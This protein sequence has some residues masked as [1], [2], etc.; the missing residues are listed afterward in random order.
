MAVSG[1]IRGL[2]LDGIGF[3]VL[4]DTNISEMVSD[5]ENENIPTSGPNILKRMRRPQNR[6][7]VV[8]QADT[9][10]RDLLIDLA[11]RLEPFPM[12]IEFA[13][14][15]IERASGFIN[16]D[17]RETEELRTTLMLLPQQGW[18]VV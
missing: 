16:I 8:V 4:A 3:Y 10:E 12:S 14:G 17:S 18:V 1:S 6:E 11:D 15:R 13:D 7:S 2:T 9:T 5:T